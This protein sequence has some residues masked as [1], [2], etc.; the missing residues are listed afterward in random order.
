ME[1][2]DVDVYTLHRPPDRLVGDSRLEITDVYW[3]VVELHTDAGHTGT[4]W[5][6]SLGF[7]P[8]MLERLAR[9]QFA[10]AVVGEDPFATEAIR[11][12]RNRTIYYGELGMSAWPRSAVDV[13]CWGINAQASGQPLYKLLGGEDDSVPAYVSSMDANHDREELAGLHGGYA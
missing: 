3:I 1:I 12:L 5:M 7:A 4:G 10:D 2:T 13:A 6:G 11:R 9:S 8:E